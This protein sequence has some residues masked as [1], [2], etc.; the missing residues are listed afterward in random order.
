LPNTLR[1][2]FYNISVECFSQQ[3]QL[4]FKNFTQDVELITDVFETYAS[5][6]KPIYKAGETGKIGSFKIVLKN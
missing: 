3:N 5:T 4:L 2:G 6:D 1:A